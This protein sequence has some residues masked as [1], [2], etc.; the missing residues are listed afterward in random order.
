MWL[1]GLPE[2]QKEER[3][4]APKLQQQASRGGTADLQERS[5]DLFGLMSSRASSYL[6]TDL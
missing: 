5:C 2:E 1:I 3:A 4:R 6:G